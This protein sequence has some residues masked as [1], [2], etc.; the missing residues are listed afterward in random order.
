MQEDTTCSRFCNTFLKQ[1]H[2]THITL[3]SGR[4]VPLSVE[5]G[6]MYRGSSERS[7]VGGGF[8]SLPLWKLGASRWEIPPRESSDPAFP[9]RQGSAQHHRGQSYHLH[10][11]SFQGLLPRAAGGGDLCSDSVGIKSSTS[12][13]QL[14]PGARTG[15]Q[16]PRAPPQA[17]APGALHKT[18]DKQQHKQDQKPLTRHTIRLLK[19]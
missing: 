8:Q 2:Q 12:W 10:T 13:P 5:L 17:Q 9:Q 14:L 18:L 19:N 11:A 15:P 4:L 1:R 6:A 3:C 16:S 7:T